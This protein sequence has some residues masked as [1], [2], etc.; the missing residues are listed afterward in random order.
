MTRAANI[1]AIE[2]STNIAWTEWLLFLESIGA[3]NLSHKEIAQHV[4]NKLKASHENSGWWAQGITVAYEQHIG[5][6]KPG[7]TNDGFFQVAVSKTLAGTI[8][9]AA[10]LPMDHALVL[11][12]TKRHQTRQD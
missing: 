12:P 4:H 2:K 6:R 5:R 11:T 8:I 7:Q 3:K 9:G 10:D 1:P